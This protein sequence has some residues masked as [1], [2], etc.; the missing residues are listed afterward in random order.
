MNLPEYNGS[1]TEP[2]R[3]FVLFL[4]H[5]V[6]GL[7][8]V[9]TLHTGLVIGLFVVGMLVWTSRLYVVV[10]HYRRKKA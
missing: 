5:L 4:L 2:L 7:V 9:V 6:L 3:T 1:M 10:R 8:A